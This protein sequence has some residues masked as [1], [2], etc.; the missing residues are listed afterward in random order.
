MGAAVAEPLGRIVTASLQSFEADCFELDSGPALGTLVVTADEPPAIYGVVCSILTQGADPSRPIAPHGLPDEDLAT[1]RSRHPHLPILLRSWFASIVSALELAGSFSYVLPD[2][3]AR[4]LS[5][6]RVCTDEEIGR[7]VRSLDF[8]E[9][10]LQR[11]EVDDDVVAALLRR[12]SATQPDSRAFLLKAGRAL[13]PIL[14]GDSA[15][16]AGILRRIR[17]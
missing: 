14:A 9:P 1:V 17:P 2:L 4:L 6:V 3:P 7:F 13:V 15:R 11:R 10:L 8:L 16:L 5:R 12:L